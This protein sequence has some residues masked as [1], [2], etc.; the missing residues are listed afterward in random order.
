MTR[1]CIITS[2]AY[3]KK[4]R[5]AF[6]VI[7]KPNI[8]MDIVYDATEHIRKVCG[9]DVPLA[10][11]CLSVDGDSF[12]D[13]QRYDPFFENMICFESIDD[14]TEAINDS[15]TLSGL[16]VAKYI[17]SVVKCTH[18]KLQ[19]L[20]YLAYADY[21]CKYSDRLFEDKIYAFKLGPVVD[22][23]YNKYKHDIDKTEEVFD[24]N[25]IDEHI[26]SVP[27]SCRIMFARCGIQKLDSIKNTIEKYGDYSAYELVDITH[28]DGAPWTFVDYKASHANIPDSIIKQYHCAES[29]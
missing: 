7:G 12:E 15:R 2:S 18:L 25:I 27:M 5:I 19:K 10:M 21:L 24:N 17:L 8:D 22:S 26:G 14:F 29:I 4:A 20:T 13:V 3:T 16:D 9:K 11:Q 28:R 1:H 6:D 23:I